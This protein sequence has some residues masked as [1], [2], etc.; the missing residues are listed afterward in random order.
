M[1]G[2]VERRVD[3]PGGHDD[4]GHE[5]R[6]VGDAGYRTF[7]V[8][9]SHAVVA[10]AEPEP[11]YVTWDEWDIVAGM[12]GELS[13]AVA[14]STDYRRDEA[15][16][17]SCM[18]ATS[19]TSTDPGSGGG[20]SVTGPP[21]VTFATFDD[22]LASYTGDVKAKM[23]DKG[24]DGCAATSSTMFGTNE[25]VARAELAR[26]KASNA[27][28][29]ELLD[30]PHGRQFEANLADPD[31]LKLVSYLGATT[32]EPGEFTAPLY[33]PPSGGGK[34]TRD[35]PDEAE[36][37]ELGTGLGCLP[38]DVDGT[39]LSLE[40]KLV[41][42][43]CLVFSTSHVFWIRNAEDLK[44]SPRFHSW[45]EYG[46]DWSCTSWFDVSD[47]TCRKHD[48]A[49]A[50]LQEMVGTSNDRELDAAWNPRN[51]LLADLK[52]KSDLQ[53]FGC[54]YPSF[55]AKLFPIASCPSGASYM[56]EAMFTAI[57]KWNNKGWLYTVHDERHVEVNHRFL[58]CDYPSVTHN[59]A[60][61]TQ[62]GTVSA[63]WSTW[64]QEAGCVY[65]IAI[66]KTELCW[67]VSYGEP[68]SSYSLGWRCT[69]VAS[70]L[71]P[72]E[73][74]YDNYFHGPLAFELAIRMHVNPGDRF[75][76]GGDYYSQFVNRWNVEIP[77]R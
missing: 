19:T 73:L 65:N 6:D 76:Y 69:P 50:T 51:K 16:L 57:H 77:V 48:V 24:T 4:L 66:V 68:S 47:A 5:G 75:D 8:V 13:A 39:R 45:L 74:T 38:E 18:S 14:T 52:A 7:R 55:L 54:T 53:R 22:V 35:G 46:D 12:I 36:L 63:S 31:D 30:T 64:R 41:V 23:E 11:V 9:V 21:A 62:D 37:P 33:D 27:V 10:S 15:A 70:D 29:A 72:V 43:D 26:L 58:L 71:S 3:G 25:S 56:A 17:M 49:L 59:I 40:N 42:L 1:A 28:Y 34:S 44:N 32:F 60:L 61:N 20:R 67:D 2:V